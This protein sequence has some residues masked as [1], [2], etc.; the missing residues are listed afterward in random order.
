[1]FVFSSMPGIWGKMLRRELSLWNRPVL[2]KI[3]VA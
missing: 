1:L 3:A 2:G